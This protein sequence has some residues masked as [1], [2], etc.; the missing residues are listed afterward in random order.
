MV[1]LDYIGFDLHKKTVVYCAKAADGTVRDQG[2]IPATRSELRGW[3]TQRP[4]PWQGA[5]E[6]TLFTGWVYDTLT[7]YPERLEAAHP[8]ML[9]AIVAAKNKNDQLD[10]ATIADLLRCNLLPACYLAPAEIRELR[11]VLRYRNLLVR[12]SV[13]MKNKISGL[14]LEC[15]VVYDR[16]RLHRKQYFEQL[17][18]N[19]E[20]TPESVAELLRLSR[21]QFE[22]F[23]LAQQRLQRGLE[24]HPSLR[25]RVA[26]LQTI[27]G[28]GPVLALTWALEVGE[29]SRFPSVRQAVSYCGLCSGQHSS[30]G[31]DKRG[32]ISKQR[33]AHLQTM[34][35]EAAKIAPRWNE[36]LAAVHARARLRG[37]RNT[38][39][40]AV[41]RKLVAYLLAVDRRQ[42][43]FKVEHQT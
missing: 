35:V 4:R 10:A 24:R 17:L 43:D 13:R 36:E 27:P 30:A 19:L 39:T 7:P 38:A 37:H 5:M 9:K 40:L 41:A 23:R 33:N 6:A 31:Q 21:T 14:L 20:E 16:A 25:E 22:S 32:P 15:G 3:A 42:S 26:R 34:L 1:D 18:D 28:V 29:V 12:L 11:R 8:A 2:S